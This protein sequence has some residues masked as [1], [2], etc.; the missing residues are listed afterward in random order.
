MTSSGSQMRI[1]VSIMKK[2]LYTLLVL[3]YLLGS[4]RMVARNA[5][6]PKVCFFKKELKISLFSSTQ[7]IVVDSYHAAQKDIFEAIRNSKKSYVWT[8]KAW[9]LWDHAEGY[10]TYTRREANEILQSSDEAYFGEKERKAFATLQK[11]WSNPTEENIFSREGKYVTEEAF[12]GQASQAPAQNKSSNLSKD[13]LNRQNQARGPASNAL[14]IETQNEASYRGEERGHTPVGKSTPPWTG[15]LG[16]ACGALA[17]G[18]AIY[19]R[20]TSGTK[21]KEK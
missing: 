8:G 2:F 7:I 4:H 20:T 10:A 16:V 1:F 14:E 21:Q 15:T 9:E 5:E 17:L 6:D 13:N 11:Q 19:A 18:Y 12:F 3:T